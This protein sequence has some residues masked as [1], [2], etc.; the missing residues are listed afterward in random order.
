VTALKMKSQEALDRAEAQFKKKETQARDGAVAMAEYNQ[1]L[2][3]IRE[4]TARLKALRRARE[5]ADA[6]RGHGM[7]AMSARA[8]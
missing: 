2:R 7:G 6:E 1:T 4:K 3:K 5:V 8:R